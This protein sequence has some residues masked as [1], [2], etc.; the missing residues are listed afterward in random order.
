MN[1]TNVSDKTLDFSNGS[2]YRHFAAPHRVL[3]VECRHGIEAKSEVHL[4]VTLWY[5]RF[6]MNW[7]TMPRNKLLVQFTSLA[8]R[9]RLLAALTLLEEV[10]IS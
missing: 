3:D 8:S 1:H 4:T 10:S 2:Q 6:S 9:D 5:T 7:I